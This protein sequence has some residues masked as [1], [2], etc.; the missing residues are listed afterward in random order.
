MGAGTGGIPGRGRWPLGLLLAGGAALL[1]GARRRRRAVG[2]AA[3]SVALLASLGA[4]SCAGTPPKAPPEPR[5][6]GGTPPGS[7]T[8]TIH[9]VAYPGSPLTFS[10]TMPLAFTVTAIPGEAAAA[11]RR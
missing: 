4:S 3:L 9:A 8:I 2:W 11:A 7:Y 10:R 6:V 1:L 5:W